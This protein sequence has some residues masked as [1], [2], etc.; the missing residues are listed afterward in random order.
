MDGIKE[1]KNTSGQSQ[2]RERTDPAWA[3]ARSIGEE[4]F[5]GES[6]KETQSEKKAKAYG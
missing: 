6:Q 3:F 5:E 2:H 4:I 1:V